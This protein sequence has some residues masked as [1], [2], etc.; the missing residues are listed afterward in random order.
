MRGQLLNQRYRLDVELGRG[1]MGVVYRAHD[2]LLDRDV[3]VKVLSE[4][5][6]NA[7]GRV[8]LLREAQAAA[9]LQHPGIVTVYDVSE[10]D[11]SSFIV[12]E[13]VQ[14]HSLHE[15]HCDTLAQMLIMFQQVCAALQHAHER[16]IIHR[17]LKP[18]NIVVT[19]DGTTKLMDFGLARTGDAPRITAEGT[20]VGTFAYL[21]PELI[22]GQPASPQSDLYALG[23]IFYECSTGHL[24]FTGE[25]MMEVLSQHLYASVVPPSTYNPEIPP[26]FEALVVR[27]LAKRAEERPASAAEVLH[28]LEGIAAHP[29]APAAVGSSGELSLLDRLVRGRLVGR[30]RELAEARAQWQHVLS[31]TEGS[32]VLLISGEPGIG[33][34]RLVRELVTLAQVSRGTALTGECFAEGSAPYAPLAQV[35]Q[36]ALSLAR[37]LPSSL[38]APVLADLLT[39][40]PTLRARF[41]NIS[42]NPPL[43]PRA[44]QQRMFASVVECCTALT[45]LLL[46]VEDVHWADGGTLSLLRHLARRARATQAQML[47]V[48]TYR[49]V[50][51]DEACALNE[52]LHD[53]NRERL[54]MRLKL[55]R[56]DHDQ[57]GELLSAIFAQQ[58]APE[59]LE[60]IYRE[61]E[62]NPFFVEEVCKALIEEGKV[63]R[64]NGRWQ[65]SSM[66]EIDLPQSVRVAIQSRV[67]KLSR[68]AQE[69]LRLAAILGREFDFDTLAAMSDLG[70]EALI[71]ALE[72]AER[73]QLV[74]EVRPTRATRGR[75][76]PAFA[77]AHALIPT[78]LHES[79]SGLRRQ[80]LHRRAAEAMERLYPDQVSSHELAPQL[81]RHYA[82]AGA[83]DRAADYWL[84]A[85]DRAR[86]VYAYPEAIGY[87]QQALA[88]L[89]EQGA[90]GLDRAARTAMKLGLLYHTT[91]HY[92]ESRQAFQDA[93]SLWQR[94][95]E[96][97]PALNAPPAPHALR[98]Y[99]PLA[100]ETLD[101][102][103]ASDSTSIAL[104]ENL[105]CGLVELTPE[106]DVMPAVA[107]TW[108]M[109]ADGREYVFRLRHDAQWSDGMPVTAG[110]F[111]FAWRRAL[112]PAMRS[113]LSQ[114][115]LDLKGARDFHE[116]R[117]ADPDSVGVRAVNEHTLLVELAEP[118]GHFLHL[119]TAVPYPLP[120]HIVQAHGEA[121]S[122][123]EHIISNGPFRLESWLEGSLLVLVRN[124][125]Y[126]G[127]SSGNLSRVE[128]DLI[129]PHTPEMLLDRYENDLHDIGQPEGLD[130]LDRA[131]LQHPGEY[132]S[133]P[134]AQVL[135]V[136]FDTTRPPFADSR[137][138]QALAHVLDRQAIADVV[139]QGA[140]SPATGGLVPP[141]VVG[142]SPGI[143]L[144][145]DPDRARRLLAEAGYVDGRGFPALNACT[146]RDGAM[147]SVVQ[148]VQAQWRDIL[149]IQIT[150]E[151]QDWLAYRERLLVAPPHIHIMGFLADY[152]DPD[153]FLRV[154]MHQPDCRWHNERYEQLLEQARQITDEAERVR[155]HQAA[156][157]L[158][159]EEAA[160]VPLLYGRNHLL[161]KPWVRCYPVS[162]LRTTY[163][164]DVVIAPH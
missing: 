147:K 53:L 43:E 110:D 17:D 97:Q 8:R 7:A 60:S 96:S 45:P 44:Q 47:I 80:R 135:Y 136:G 93:F 115:L 87:L 30:D 40:A 3:A 56:L 122:C 54:A 162:P 6:L 27:L 127:R 99:W 59:L 149:G 132:V 23:V 32:R 64:E 144:A 109:S 55:T 14:G 159:V 46:V 119:V 15:H 112:S 79:V 69:A 90:G 117:V 107:R 11:G 114:L 13:Y 42:P 34:T 101:P 133:A 52:L 74:V 9:R 155:F 104:I 88:L 125:T 145:Y 103:L 81:G 91:F 143:G 140:V 50:E 98:L 66:E 151:Q 138:R 84:A 154:A 128:L 75:S 16:S 71:V 156:D 1:G 10:T 35:I 163:W 139:W 85:G 146:A 161:V 102:T 5:S 82:E 61:T 49:E 134:G 68:E 152:P 153:S 48:M 113:P 164:K 94:A 26:A 73:A 29:V 51:L 2:M 76:C 36:E 63:T 57:T 77:F 105:F 33:K 150:W 72:S 108:E 89:R 78:A 92:R 24:P 106:L 130:M 120:R 83:W 124:P 28:I 37:P 39:L 65:R 160:I 118:V 123:A 158:L 86:E 31:G 137:V 19:P 142:Y 12:M 21:A 25:N 38:P 67:N 129:G 116:G 62:G 148:Y 157:R 95:G 131:R 41:R 121:W 111:E 18:E 58:V 4:A 126:R 141:G 100:I 20:L 70:E 22:Q